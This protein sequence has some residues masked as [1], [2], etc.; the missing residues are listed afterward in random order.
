M[1]TLTAVAVVLLVGPA[2][3]QG[4]LLEPGQIPAAV[5]AQ[6]DAARKSDPASFEALAQVRASLGALD[7]QKRGRQPVVSPVLR[8]L[9]P[10]ALFPLIREAAI[11]A[12]PRGELNAAAWDAWRRAVLEVLGE[13]RSPLAAPVF[14]A[15]L[16]RTDADFETHRAAA[17]ALGALGDDATVRTL[18]ALSGGPNRSA[19]LAGMGSC[20]RVAIAQTLAQAV[21]AET[22]ARVLAHVAR[23]LGAVGNAWAWRTPGLPAPG[24]EATVR[25]I[26]ARALVQAFVKGDPFARQAASNA[27]M[28]VDAPETPALIQEARRIAP[29]AALDGLA[30]RFAK[31]PTRL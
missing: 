23:S 21:A 5:R 2:W 9:G 29:S 19:V 28:V 13:L 26:A 8:D 10:R 4:V 14:V 22:D 20:R 12:A 3:A 30:Q 1:K 18:V 27:L 17:A 6:V 25:A 16:A 11:S 24:E 31:N 7:A 15:V